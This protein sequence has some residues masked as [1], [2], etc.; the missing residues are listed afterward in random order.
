MPIIEDPKSPLVE[1]IEKRE[2]RTWTFEAQSF[3]QKGFPKLGKYRMRVVTCEEQENALFMA[4]RHVKEK[5]AAAKAEPE[6]AQDADLIGNAKVAYVMYE[7]CRDLEKDGPAFPSGK[8]LVKN[9]STDELAVLV[10]HYHEILKLSGPIDLDLST[11]RVEGLAAVMAAHAETD[12]PNMVLMAF[13]RE[14]VCEI[15]I[16]LSLLLKEARQE[17]GRLTV[18]ASPSRSE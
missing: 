17:I 2:R 1:A 7:A 3:L 11:E 14:Q 5:V 6:M 4:K 15:A 16:R 10:N 18:D 9:L 13:T 12:A 8:W